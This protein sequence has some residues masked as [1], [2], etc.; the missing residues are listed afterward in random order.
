MPLWK[1]GLLVVFVITVLPL[2]SF[3]AGLAVN[4]PSFSLI[5]MM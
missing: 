3:F 5:G 1:I 4:V 2:L